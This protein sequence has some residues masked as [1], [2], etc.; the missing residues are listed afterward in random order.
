MPVLR[1]RIHKSG[2]AAIIPVYILIMVLPNIILMA[3][4]GG[5][6]IS[7]PVIA[8]RYL[9]PGGRTGILLLKSIA[10]GLA[11]A[12]ITLIAGGSCAAGLSNSKSRFLKG[13]QWWIL[14]LMII[15][16]FIHAIAWME[17]LEFIGRTFQLSV[18]FR[19]WGAGIWVQA[20]YM[21]PLAV[22]FAMIS[23][24][25]V[26][27]E[28]VDA[29]RLEAEDGQ[30][31]KRIV[32]P[33]ALP[34]MSAGAS[35]IFAL[36]LLDYTIMSI[37]GA[38]NYA[39][40]IFSS[41][42][43][44]KST[45]KA[46]L[47]SVPMILLCGCM[48]YLFYRELHHRLLTG[49]RRGSSHHYS[50]K[51]PSVFEYAIGF[52]LMI[53]IFVVLLPLI[54][55]LGDFNSWMRIPSSLAESGGE[56]LISL[57][58]AF[59]AVILSLILAY[60]ISLFAAVG[61]RRSR[62]LFLFVIMQLSVPSSL[63]GISLIRTFNLILPDFLY[64]SWF[65]PVIAQSTRF[66]PIIVLILVSQIQSIDND[67]I[68]AAHLETSRWWDIFYYVRLPL[69]KHGILASSLTAFA[70]CMGELGAT[71]LVIPPGTSTLTIKIYNYLHYGSTETVK[72]LC[73]IIFA[74]CLVFGWGIKKGMR[75]WE[76]KEFRIKTGFRGSGGLDG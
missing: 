13:F 8:L 67:L 73:L 6:L 15:P 50:L 62:F 19:G 18:G 10:S 11:V 12:M 5:F 38:N 71:L 23:F 47:T 64:N 3:D 58:I 35:V 37:F 53:L 60:P 17:G 68:E 4:A 76:D 26:E 40:E 51:F 46:F 29:A 33:L 25:S 57:G 22:S 55:L 30:I 14:I 65:L 24:Q 49:A 63:T 59:S 74:G 41:F 32:L 28:W 72:S 2:F 43:G 39:L 48:I 54:V 66:L 34:L 61:K 45:G 69:L 75:L 1:K 36:S 70:L 31:F 56:I 9:L 21:L 27:E 16:P 44:S 7:S 42:S 52:C 20:M